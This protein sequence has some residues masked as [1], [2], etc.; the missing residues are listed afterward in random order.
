MKEQSPQNNPEGPKQH[1]LKEFERLRIELEA[2]SRLFMTTFG[3]V[4]YQKYMAW[5]DSK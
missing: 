5:E 3:M 1:T 2:K 4:N